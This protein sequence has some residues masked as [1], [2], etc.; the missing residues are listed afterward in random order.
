MIEYRAMLWK[1]KKFEGGF[2]L[3]QGTPVYVRETEYGWTGSYYTDRG[4]CHSFALAEDDFRILQSGDTAIEQ[5]VVIPDPPE[6]PE[7]AEKEKEMQRRR[8]AY[9]IKRH[10][11][12]ADELE[13]LLETL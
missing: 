11:E 3:T 10:R 9:S 12:A 8:V 1:D 6:P 2:R 5:L 7:K 4:S 13:R